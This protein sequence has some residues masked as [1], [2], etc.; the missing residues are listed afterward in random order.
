[1]IYGG[2]S[3][4]T[5]NFGAARHVVCWI[6]LVSVAFAVLFLVDTAE[7][8]RTIMQIPQSI[9]STVNIQDGAALE[10]LEGL[11]GDVSYYRCDS[12]AAAAA[13]TTTTTTIVSDASMVDVPHY[14][15]VLLHGAAFTKEDW[16]T[17]GI[18]QKLCLKQG[19]TV[20]ALDLHVRSTHDLLKQTLQGLANNQLVTLPL[21]GLV[22]PSASGFAII[23]WLANG[24]VD[25][26]KEYVSSWIPVASPAVMQATDKDLAALA[27]FPVL[28]IYGDR[29]ARGKQVS[30]RL[31][32]TAGATKVE[33]NG[34]HPCY[35]DSPDAF[36]DTVVKYLRI[37]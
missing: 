21:T 27:S 5:A 22:T 9:T 3:A 35:L 20:T 37:E 26:L 32:N 12:T 6:V 23:D 15:L 4:G 28:A 13:T 29:D 11:V 19:V 1:M 24:S 16:K 2:S 14:D 36:V 33:L 10:I 34:G 25:Q 18:L 31:E 30:E 8:K 17:S 7:E